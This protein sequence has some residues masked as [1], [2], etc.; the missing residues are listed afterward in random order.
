MSY[1][2]DIHVEHIRRNGYNDLSHWMSNPDNIY[3]GRKGILIINSERFPKNDSLWAN[4][5]KIGRD[6]NREEVLN[7]YYEYITRKIVNENLFDELKKLKG[8]CLGCWCVG[9]M[10]VTNQPPPWICHGQIL[11]YLVNYFYP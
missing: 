10:T 7:K 6:G 3:I 11:M 9:N 1:L 5:Y 2:C 8:K 4:P